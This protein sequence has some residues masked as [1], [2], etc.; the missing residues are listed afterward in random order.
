MSVSASTSLTVRHTPFT[1]TESPRRVSSARLPTSIVSR[2]IPPSPTEITRP[3]PSTSPV[4]KL[5]LRL[6][7]VQR[8]RDVLPHLLDG[9]DT[10][11]WRP[12]HAGHVQ[13]A[14]ERH[15]LGP[16]QF[17]GVEQ[18][19][20]VG[21]P[22]PHEPASRLPASLNQN[23]PD[24]PPAQLLKHEEEVQLPVHKRRQHDRYAQCA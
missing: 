3:I 23:A 1:E 21:E 5:L 9:V 11:L 16:K 22:P 7:R 2:A 6:E 14:H 15:P 19:Q 4:N 18:G 10:E 24:A 20:L 8:H 13:G 17:R 12:C